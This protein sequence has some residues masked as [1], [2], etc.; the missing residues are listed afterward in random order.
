MSTKPKPDFHQVNKAFYMTGNTGAN[1]FCKDLHPP[2]RHLPSRAFPKTIMF[3]KSI[4][5]LSLAA[6]VLAA[7]A[8]E[9]VEKRLVDLV[10]P[11]DVN[12]D[13]LVKAHLDVD[14]HA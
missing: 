12:V 3:I 13:P 5:A 14:L 10:G 4:I 9:Q 8:V 7:P 1:T 6:F 11:V 2:S